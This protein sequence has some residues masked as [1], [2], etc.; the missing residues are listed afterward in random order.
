MPPH[1]TLFL[2]TEVYKKYGN[3]RLDMGSAADYELMLRMLY[4]YKIKIKYIPEILVKMRAG[5][6]SNMSLA[7]RLKANQ[8]DRRAWEVNKLKPLPFTLWLK[9]IRKI[10][11][12]L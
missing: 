6:V 5:G 2:R 7:N 12:F 9:P 8:N 11:Q 1:P 4:K 3:F 10:H